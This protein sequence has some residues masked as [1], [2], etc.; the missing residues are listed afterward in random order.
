MLVDAIFLYVF[1]SSCHA[2]HRKPVAATFNVPCVSVFLSQLCWQVSFLIIYKLCHPYLRNLA[3]VTFNVQCSAGFVGQCCWQI[4]F[5]LIYSLCYAYL[6]KPMKTLLMFNGFLDFWASYAGGLNFLL[7]LKN[8]CGTHL[9]NLVK[10]L[11]SFLKQPAADF[12]SSYT[13]FS[14]Y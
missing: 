9:P 12:L 14:K 3:A 6:G 1:Y 7:L 10:W 2:Y 13:S 4:Y 5:L 8:A 11:V